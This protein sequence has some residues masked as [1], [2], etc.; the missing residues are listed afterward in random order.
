MI[1]NGGLQQDTA[2]RREMVSAS[3]V[4]SIKMDAKKTKSNSENIIR[5]R[6]HEGINRRRDTLI[7]KAHELG[8]FDGVDV[9]LII[10][11]HGRFTTYRS[12]DRKSWPPSTE[13]IVSEEIARLTYT[14]AANTNV[15]NCVSSS[16][17]STTTR[18]RKA[19]IREAELDIS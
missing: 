17:E 8:A 18:H 16:K 19:E 7:K 3:G 1:D 5:K 14:T 15:G 12:R 2:L 4:H 11:K 9:Y 13:E 10:C 6:K